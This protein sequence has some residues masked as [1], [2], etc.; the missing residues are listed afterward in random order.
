MIPRQLEPEV[1]ASET[2][3]VDYDA[4]DHREVNRRFVDD[5]LEFWTP[6]GTA[7]DLG[8]GTALIP[9]E[10]C[11][12]AATA[13]VVGIDMSDAMIALGQKNIE[14]AGLTDAIR[15]QLA[16]AKGLPF[17]D[18]TFD[19]VISNSIV[20]HIPEPY[21]VLAEAIRVLAPGGVMFVRDLMR[22][23]DEVSVDLLVET[24]STGDSSAQ[25]QMFADSL[26]AALTLAEMRDLVERLGFD[27]R[28]VQP[29]SDRHWTWRVR[30]HNG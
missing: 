2:E 22:P 17:D 23:D 5:L 6:T 26:R 20:H 3:A 15:L 29:T 30:G 13:R 27:A 10:L 16:D 24:Y 18:R 7:L 12:V 21:A 25:R 1:M 8:T 4:I 14:A 28:T 19:A 11:R 9:I